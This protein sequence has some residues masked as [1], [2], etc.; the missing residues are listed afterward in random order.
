VPESGSF[1][2]HWCVLVP[3]AVFSHFLEVVLPESGC[4]ELHWCILVS[5]WGCFK[6]HWIVLVS[7]TGCFEPHWSVV[8]S[9]HDISNFTQVFWYL[10]QAVSNIIEVFLY[11]YVDVSNV[12]W[13]RLCFKRYMKQTFEHHW[14]V[15]VTQTVSNFSFDIWSRIIFTIYVVLYIMVCGILDINTTVQNKPI[16]LFT[17]VLFNN[18]YMFQY[19]FGTSPGSFIKYVSCCWNILI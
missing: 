5:E 19:T 7:E 4:V 15:S 14:G 2:I 10:N 6:L 16:E 11:L 12:K 18:C 13:N 9:E 8:V 17:L 1:K 3:E